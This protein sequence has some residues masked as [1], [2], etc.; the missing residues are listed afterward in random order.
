MAETA[1]ASN[2]N[3]LSLSA[4]SEGDGLV[5]AA[6]LGLAAGERSAVVPVDGRAAGVVAGDAE[7]VTLEGVA[8]DVAE[9]VPDLVAVEAVGKVGLG[10]AGVEA[11]AVAG[12]LEGAAASLGVDGERLGVA[13]AGLESVAHGDVLA[14]GPDGDFKVALVVDLGAANG[15]DGAGEAG[16]DGEDAELLEHF[17]GCWWVFVLRKRK[18]CKSV[19]KCSCECE[20][21]C[22]EEKD[23]FEGE[24]CWVFIHELLNTE[25]YSSCSFGNFSATKSPCYHGKAEASDVDATLR[26]KPC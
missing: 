7:L 15:R 16:G 25:S 4:E 20:C 8:K 11:V 18:C 14:D 9:V 12:D 3:C 5:G 21:E 1:K 13:G 24:L 23:Q 17:E 10:L 26:Q 2:L 19:C 6:D 22:D